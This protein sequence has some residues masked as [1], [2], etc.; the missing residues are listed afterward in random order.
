[1]NL[2]EGHDYVLIPDALWKHLENWYGGGPDYSRNVISLKGA[3]GAKKLRTPYYN[4]PGRDGVVLEMHP[5]VL[6]FASMD[7]RT[8]RPSKGA[9]EFRKMFSL[10]NTVKDMKKMKIKENERSII[11][12][13][14]MTFSNYILTEEFLHW[15]MPRT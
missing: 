13:M 8:G 14:K 7:L 5:L 12:T 2:L 1:M 6:I 10:V 9:K 11:V 3:Q 4:P 15:K